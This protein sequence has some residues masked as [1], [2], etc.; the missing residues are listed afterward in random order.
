MQHCFPLAYF[1]FVHSYSLRCHRAPPLPSSTGMD[2]S[3]RSTGTDAVRHFQETHLPLLSCVAVLRGRDALEYVVDPA[4][5][6]GQSTHGLYFSTPSLFG[7]SSSP[8]VVRGHSRPFLHYPRSLFLASNGGGM[9]YTEPTGGVRLSAG[10]EDSHPASN[11]DTVVSLRY[12]ASRAWEMFTSRAYLHQ[13]ERYGLT[14]ELLMDCFAA[15]EQVAHC[16]GSLC[17]F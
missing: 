3:R 5:F 16:Y 6:S 11:G 10:N 4:G 1:N 13:Y 14:T 17:W 9:R 12:V 7:K 15:V 2:W 8:L